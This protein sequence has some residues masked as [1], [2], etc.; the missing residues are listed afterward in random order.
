MRI[1]VAIVPRAGR[2]LLLA[3]LLLATLPWPGLVRAQD[4][5]DT[6]L[7]F[8]ITLEPDVL[9]AA[10]AFVRLVRIVL[11]PGAST[12]THM[13]PG[14]E[15][16]RVEAGTLTVQVDGPALVKRRD[17]TGEAFEPA[18]EGTPFELERGEQITY[19]PGTAMTFRNDSDETVRILAAVVLPAE[20]SAGPR[21]TYVDGDPD[22]A[23]LRGLS[24]QVLGDGVARTLPAS[25]ASIVIERVRLGDEQDLPGERNPTLVSLESGDFAFDLD[26]GT[27][28]VSRTA[29]PGPQADLVAGDDT[30]LEARDAVFFPN[31]FGTV[32]REGQ[33]G[34]L[35]YLRMVLAPSASDERLPD[36]GKATI[37]FNKVE[38]RATET[39]AADDGSASDETPDDAADA[40]DASTVYVTSSDVNLR[41][42]P[43]T[44]AAIV[45]TYQ[46]GQAVTL[47]GEAVEAEGLRWFP[48]T[49]PDDGLSGYISADFL[50]RQPDGSEPL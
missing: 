42:E 9:P 48:V 29:K 1:P 34:G 16:G 15:F 2:V 8:R 47:T 14:P 49:N 12:P 43:S 36:K 35:T 19:L 13:H 17:S 30:S 24:S 6:D 27:A 44:Q 46:T 39:P 22:E 18:D 26:K 33:E 3:A 5:L 21:I 32:N 28:Q 40:A 20:E 38:A 31:G 41:A 45:A 7:L 23:A 10:P 37:S 50:S 25:G 11:E 4:E